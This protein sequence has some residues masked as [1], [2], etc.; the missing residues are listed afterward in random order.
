MDRIIIFLVGLLLGVVIYAIA[1]K[2]ST[3]GTLRIDQS[4]PCDPPYLF[5]EVHKSIDAIAS[6]SHVTLKVNCK[7][8]VTH[9]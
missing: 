2:T 6:K 4:D 3:V 5:L 8:F 7:D 1:L 9:D